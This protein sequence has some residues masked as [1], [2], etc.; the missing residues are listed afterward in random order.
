MQC[1]TMQVL[2]KVRKTVSRHNMLKAGDTVLVGVSGGADSV[3][4]LHIL[5]RLCKEL[6][7]DLVAAHVHHG[8]RGEE[9]E[10]DAAFV[11]KICV[12]WK[13]PFRLEKVSVPELAQREH[14]S[15]ETAG[16]L[17]RYRCFHE[18]CC[19]EKIDRIATAHN[20]DDQSETLLMRI[21]RGT[22][23]DG[24]AGIRP[25]REDG[26]IRPLLE[27][28]REEIE[29][30]C[31]ENQLEYRNDSTN[32]ENDYTRNRIRNYL[33]PILKKEFNP[34]IGEALSRLSQNM[35][36]DGVFLN[37][38]TRR[39]YR[40]INS[41]LPR[42]RPV[43]LDIESLKLVA[44][45]IRIRLLRL[46][47][48]DAMGKG[49]RADYSHWNLVS[50]LLDKNTGTA[51]MLPDGLTVTVQYGWLAFETPKEQEERTK[52]DA[53]VC[54][55]VEPGG[56]Y[57][58]EWGTV[59]LALCDSKQPRLP[60]Q[61]LISYDKLE[62]Q[63]LELRTRRAGDRIAVFQDGRE[64]KLKDFLIDKK[65]PRQER[66]RLL[67]LCSGNQVIAVIGYRVAEPYKADANTKR[68]LRVTYGKEDESR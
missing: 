16:R 15:L 37:D 8:I 28:S 56:V 47:A 9:A 49:Y 33:L 39:L 36:E 66:E 1:K 19:R 43:V 64:K 68:E 42:R 59:S 13:I 61:M 60:N 24:L 21:L 63:P 50:E 35:E 26:V 17:A 38:Y 58:T 46:A 52:A 22:G 44:P 65:I 14:L 4:L 32:A 53:S 2:D 3:C 48:E 6:G 45:S 41:P 51:V 30:Y 18:I 23:I 62:G 11:R 31:A 54:Y 29:G 5:K 55:T 27:V 7:I 20:R 10:L 40:R 25:V 67:L 12:D 57:T 34:Q